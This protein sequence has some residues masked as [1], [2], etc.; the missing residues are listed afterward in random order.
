[1]GAGEETMRFRL[2]NKCLKALFKCLFLPEDWL[3]VPWMIATSDVIEFLAKKDFIRFREVC[4]VYQ[5]PQTT[6]VISVS[7][8]GE[9]AIFK[10]MCKGHIDI[11]SF[12]INKNGDSLISRDTIDALLS[13]LGE[14][15]VYLASPTL[16]VRRAAKL[17]ARCLGA[18]V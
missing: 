5:E 3:K 16:E 14:L 13:S 1:L 11:P 9:E 15:P 6:P 7:E 12:C 4:L 10:A 8:K 2:D 17:R 18:E